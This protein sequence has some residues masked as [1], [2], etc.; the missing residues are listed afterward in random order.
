M[1]TNPKSYRPSFECLEDRRI[2][3]VLSGTNPLTW[4]NL[5][6]PTAAKSA[7]TVGAAA[8]TIGDKMAAFLLS[9]VGRR[10]GGGECAD[11]ATEALRV[12]GGKFVLGP[13]SPSFGDFV[14]GSL[15]TAVQFTGGHVAY[16]NP[17]AKIR[18]G[19]VLQYRN[20]TFSTGITATH[21]TAVVAAVNALG[22]VTAVFEQNFGTLSG[23][24]ASRFV[25][26][27]ALDLAKLTGGWVRA[28]RPVARAI[29]PSRFEFTIVNNTAA[30]RNFQIKVGT[31]TLAN[32]MLDKAN[33]ANSF[34]VVWLIDGLP[35]KPTIVVNG[36]VLTVVNGGGYELFTL[37]NGTPSVRKLIP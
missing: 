13:D 5:S 10:V 27:H 11:M 18:V 21:H 23:G 6:A 31:I 2:P 24:P 8:V 7:P 17:A 12:A 28:Y 22:R 19:D 26:R 15:V 33:K 20:A 29:V 1:D 25:G 34:M 35:T 9:K 32:Y 16:S 37:A 14:W 36:H 3:A 30:V 4:L